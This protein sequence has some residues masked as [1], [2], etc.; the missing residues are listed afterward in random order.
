M[1]INKV[2]LSIVTEYFNQ[3]TTRFPWLLMHCYSAVRKE[4]RHL[5]EDF[6]CQEEESTQA[7][8]AVMVTSDLK[9]KRS[10]YHVV[11]KSS[12]KFH[13]PEAAFDSLVIE[14]ITTVFVDDNKLFNEFLHKHGQSVT[15]MLTINRG[16]LKFYSI[17]KVLEKLPNLQKVQFIRVNYEASKENPTIPQRY[18][19]NLMEVDVR[20]HGNELKQKILPA[21]K[22][23]AI[24]NLT[25]WYPEVALEE[26][27][28]NFANLEEL[29]V[30]IDEYYQARDPKNTNLNIVKLKVL[31]IHL[32][33]SDDEIVDKVLDFI[34]DQDNLQKFSLTTTSRHSQLFCKKLIDHIFA[35]RHLT[36][37]EIG[38]EDLLKKIESFLSNAESPNIL[39]EE[40]TCKLNDI[41]YLPSSFLVGFTNVIKLNLDCMIGNNKMYSDLIGAMNQTQLVEIDLKRVPAGKFY[42]F[43][44]LKLGNLLALHVEIT[45][46]S[47]S[48]LVYADLKEILKNHPKITDFKLE[49]TEKYEK[50]SLMEFIT[51]VAE[52]LQQLKTLQVFSYDSEIELEEIKKVDALKNV[53][54]RINDFDS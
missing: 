7:P 11:C 39:V 20:N 54:W 22:E 25:A 3:F 42:F 10:Q 1:D 30:N 15:K 17:T 6:Y 40:W 27:L 18:C 12:T 2:K 9:L 14:D 33:T 44:Q 48:E 23:I 16:S 45:K 8:L 35:L 4:A 43:T 5:F 47:E 37:L 32:Y 34:Q 26:I 36:S 19:Q 46:L 49:L 41:N 31:K 51:M 21:F 50:Q 28:Q 24:K 29:R 53:T 38:G 13:E 52:A